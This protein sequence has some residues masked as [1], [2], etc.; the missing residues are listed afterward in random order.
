[1]GLS[2]V[3]S[4]CLAR[5]RPAPALAYGPNMPLKQLR[6]AILAA[7]EVFVTCPFNEQGNIVLLP[8][9][10]AAALDTI[11]RMKRTSRTVSADMVFGALVI[12]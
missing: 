1:M 4:S 2:R 11:R 8:V 10:K 7:P 9:T 12:G 5:S 3:A 6:A